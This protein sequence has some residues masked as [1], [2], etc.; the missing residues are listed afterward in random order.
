MENKHDIPIPENVMTEVKRRL[1]EISQLL[2]G[3]IIP[4]TPAE[5]RRII[6]MGEKTYSFVSKAYELAK[7]NPEL[8]PK[9]LDINDFQIDIEDVMKLIT[10][11]TSLNQIHEGVADTEMVAGSEAY[12]SALEF[13]QEVKRAAKNDIYGAKAIYEELKKR[14]PTRKKSNN[15]DNDPD[16]D[17]KHI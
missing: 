14:F 8:C 3:Y 1:S 16:S 4:L 2:R 11:K 9:Y 5:R 13:Y 10:L 6:K 7:E 17:N 15:T 12:Q